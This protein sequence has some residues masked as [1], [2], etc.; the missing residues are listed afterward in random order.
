[1]TLFKPV[2]AYADA[3][4]TPPAR[5]T[6]GAAGYDM[7]AAEDIIVPSFWTQMDKM[8]SASFNADIIDEE[9]LEYKV[10]VDLDKM[11]GITK[12]ADARPTLIPTGFKVYLEPNQYLK[13]VSR[14]SIP[15]KD[16]IILANG[17]GT[18]DADYVDNPDNEGLIYF[19]V[20]NL[21]PLPILIRKGDRIGQGI[22]LHYDVTDDDDQMEKADRTGGFGST[23]SN[24]R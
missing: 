12:T 8:L 24:S 20:I 14:S 7:C 22:I 6:K 17:T 4:L 13:L 15:T 21:S 18:I 19:P 1:M 3:G 10:V 9:S 23:G 11:S 2:A 5:A 16:W